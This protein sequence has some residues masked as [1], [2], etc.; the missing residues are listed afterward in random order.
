MKT[1]SAVR[2]F[3]FA[4]A[5]G[6]VSCGNNDK[7]NQQTAGAPQA[8]PYPVIT[9]P[10]KTVTGFTSYPTSIEGIVNSGVRAKVQGYIQEVLVDEGQ[11]VKKGQ[12]LFR[13]ETQSL[14][15]DAAAAKA[16]VN[17]AQ[18]EV[19]KLKPLVAK[20]IISNVQ[21]ET[22]KANLERAK[23]TYQG[24]AANIG[25]ATVKSPVD[26]FV[27][28][29][30]FRQG[31]LVGPNDQTP[32]TTVTDIKQVYAYFSMN[33]SEYL[34]FLQKTEGATLSDKIK[35][36]P[37]VTLVL[38]NGSE[39][40]QKGKIETVTGQVNANTG[41]VSFRAVFENPSQLITNGNSGTIKVPTTYKN[42]VVVPME[43]TFEQQGQILVFKAENNTAKNVVIEIKGQ[44]DNL[45]VV[46]SGLAKGDKIVAS[47]GKLRNDTPIQPQEVPFDSIAKPI[48]KVFKN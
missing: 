11:K 41:T 35:N 16:S 20:N 38:A 24:V 26:G 44:V 47:I 2:I 8:M 39:F 4:I 42:A 9:I 27:G 13:L 3:Y 46:K 18:V 43:S 37:E 7:N 19:D 48:I 30:P 6:L 12:P 23:S 29:I 25:Y 32:L 5:I 15:Q 10:A 22:A 31:A 45:Y 17:A 36:F 1:L 34:T 33:E 21:L 28:A 14:S 40:E